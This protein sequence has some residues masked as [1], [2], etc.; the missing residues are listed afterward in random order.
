LSNLQID[1]LWW[2]ILIPILL[3]GIALDILTSV[4]I[5]QSHHF[6][7]D[8]EHIQE[9]IQNVLIILEM[10]VFSVIQQYAYHVAPYSGADRAKIEKKE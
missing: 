1:Q 2:T 3:Q 9:A 7:L 10:V 6:W 4:G 5:I 8:V